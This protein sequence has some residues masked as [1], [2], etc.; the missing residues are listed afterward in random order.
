MHNIVVLVFS[1][2]ISVFQK[3]A[4]MAIYTVKIGICNGFQT[5]WDS[6]QTSV[7]NVEKFPLWCFCNLTYVHR[8]LGYVHKFMLAYTGLGF[9]LAFIF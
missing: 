6:F 4:C 1:C 7:F 9:L 5:M 3:V 2:G 8:L